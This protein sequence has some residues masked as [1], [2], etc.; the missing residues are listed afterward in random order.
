MVRLDVFPLKAV[1][2]PCVERHDGNAQD[3]FVANF[4]SCAAQDLAASGQHAADIQALRRCPISQL[5]VLSSEPR[6]KEIPVP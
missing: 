6:T 3:E 5:L 1:S 2:I 4:E